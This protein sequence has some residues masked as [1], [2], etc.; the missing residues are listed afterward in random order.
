MSCY[1]RQLKP[2]NESQRPGEIFVFQTL[3][4][5]PCLLS[6]YPQ[7]PCCRMRDAQTSDFKVL[8]VIF[9]SLSVLLFNQNQFN[10]SYI[11]QIFPYILLSWVENR[12]KTNF[13]CTQT[14]HLADTTQCELKSFNPLK[15]TATT[16]KNRMN[17]TEL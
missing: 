1:N 12:N 16:Q 5:W 8:F 4:I 11:W 9:F 10:R 6:D 3:M 17:P 7:C 14:Q 2:F 13:S 15:N